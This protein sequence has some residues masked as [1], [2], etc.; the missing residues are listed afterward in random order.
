MNLELE[1]KVALVTGGTA[2]IGLAIARR[3][4]EEGAEVVICGREKMKLGRVAEE[5]DVRGI[6][7]DV[8]TAEGARKLHQALPKIDI[9][10]N[11]LGISESKRFEDISDDDW[12]RLFSVNVL[13]GARLSR[14][15]F[16][17][18]VEAGWG[19]IVF[20]ASD[21]ALVV[22]PDMVHFGTTKTALL[23]ISRGLAAASKSTGVTV[24]S[25]LPGTT[26]S[27]EIEEFLRSGVSD[28]ATSQ[29]EIERQYFA[30]ERPTSLIQRMIDPDEVANLVAY[31]ASPLSSATNGAALR[32]DGGFVPTIT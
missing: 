7:A 23:G 21:A 15:Y 27:D 10:V 14:I 9:L 17:A 20:I 32:V 30:V 29:V 16:P 28:S 4:S 5:I 3:L 1:G 13:S 6:L 22:P 8:T 18:M 19:R 11:N 2:G 24:N 12:L 26:R 25:I 31:V